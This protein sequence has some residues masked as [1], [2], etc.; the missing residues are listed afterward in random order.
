MCAI[1]VELESLLGEFSIRMKGTLGPRW[2]P[3]LA[4]TLGRRRLRTPRGAEPPGPGP[5]RARGCS[6]W[7]FLTAAPE[8][9][10]G[11][12]ALARSLR[13]PVT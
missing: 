4:E 11:G 7:M 9:Q 5:P 2:L 10:E 1:E 12:E 6:L 13:T 8:T 3:F